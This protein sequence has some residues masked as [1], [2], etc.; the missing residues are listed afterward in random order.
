MKIPKI[1]LD[2]LWQNNTFFKVISVLIACIIWVVVAMNMKTDIPR[3]IKEVPVTTDNQ[4]SFISKMGLTV[5]GDESLF[6]DVTIEGQRLVV[7]SIKPEDI[8]VSVDLSSVNGSGSFSLPLVAENVSGKNFTISSISPSTV[9]LK[10]DRMV[11]KKF[12]V[13]LEMEGLTVPEEGYLMEEAVVNPTQI[14]I[15]GPDTDIAKIA[16]CVVFVNYEG[17]LTKTTTFTSDIVLLDKDGHEIDTS[18]LTM[19]VKQAEVVVPILKT[20]DLPVTVSFLNVP[21]NLNL[22]TLKYT[23]SNETITVAGPVD[24][25]GKYSEI[26]LGYIDFKSLDLDSSFTFDVELPED[27]TNVAHTETVTVTFDWTDMVEKEFTVTNLSLMNIPAD[28]TAKLLTNKITKVKVIGPAQVLESMT[29]DDL[30]AQ[31][32]LS[33]RAVE[34][35]QFK[36]AV[37]ISAPTKNLVWAVGDYTAVVVVSEK[38]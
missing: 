31:I 11:T 20:V 16:K 12:N 30:V 23:I 10:F 4:T 33:K 27:F 15:T 18:M 35:G 5:I 19:D 21:S 28:Y 38:E 26:V 24:E 25:I 1:R 34:T 7:G 37:T 8:S 2:S 17:N 32:D 6:V 36:T 13:D 29:S 3:A 14:S 9:N 22:E